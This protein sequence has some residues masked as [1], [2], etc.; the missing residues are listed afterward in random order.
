LFTDPTANLIFVTNM[1]RMEGVKLN[2]FAGIEGLREIRKYDEKKSVFFYVGDENKAMNKFKEKKVSLGEVIIGV[3][4]KE[5]YGY[6]TKQI[7][8]TK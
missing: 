6:I 4:A 5:V 8:F 7:T 1:T 2:E 3:N